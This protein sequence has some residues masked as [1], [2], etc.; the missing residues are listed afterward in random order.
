MT[1]LALALRRALVF[2]GLTATG[3]V[4]FF[5]LHRPD[6]DARRR[7][8]RESGQPV[9]VLAAQEY[10][11]TPR[12]L[13][14]GVVEA[15]RNWQGLAE[16]GG[17]VVETDERLEVGRRI[18]EGTVLLKI[19]PGSYELEKTKTEATVKAVRAQIGELK[20]REQSARANLKVEEKVLALARKDLARLQSLYDQGAVALTEVETA[21][22]ELLSAE[23]SVLSYK[24][25]LSELPASRKV[26]EANLQQYKAGV[27]GAALELARTEV[28]APFTMRL[29]EVNAIEG[30][31]VSAG[32]VLVVGDAVDVMEV[33]A[34]FSIASITPLRAR[35]GRGPRAERDAETTTAGS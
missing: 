15:Q 23:R 29:R 5:W 24:N 7:R 2:S 25:T 16:V 3:V 6:D 27:K 30:Q 14:Y 9:R 10:T 12:A 4:V 31:A 22:R 8:S 18:R 33:P 32:Q 13:G 34:Q 1:S 21:E 11:A 19:D 20:A 17:K 35:G 26:L 28:I